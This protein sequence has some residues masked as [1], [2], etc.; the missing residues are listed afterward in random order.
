MSDPVDHGQDGGWGWEALGSEDDT[1]DGEAEHDPEIEESR[2]GDKVSS[3]P[4]TL[5]EKSLV[6]K[7]AISSLQGITSS[8]SFQE[9]EKAIGATLALNLSH[10][11][12]TELATDGK[13]S[14]SNGILVQR[15]SST[16]LTQQKVIQHRMRQQF[17]QNHRS[18][19]FNATFKHQYPSSV[20]AKSELAPF[21]NESESRA[22]ILFHTPALSQDAVREACSKFGVLYYIRPEFHAKGV[23]FISYFDLQAAT[24][25]KVSIT[26]VLGGS[27]DVSVH[28]SIMLHATNSNTEEFRLVVKNL[29]DGGQEGEI[30]SI[31][32]R[33]GQLR[34]IQKTF[35]S[36]ADLQQAAQAKLATAYS[37]EYYNIQDAR[38]AA[39]ELSAT[40]ANIWSPETT[41]KFAP[42]DERKQ[43][44]CQQLLATLSRW[45][46]EMAAAASATMQS[47]TVAPMHVQPHV[48][49]SSFQQVMPPMHMHL[50]S[51]AGLGYSIPPNAFPANFINMDVPNV[52]MMPLNTRMGAPVPLPNTA[53]GGQN[54]FQMSG[55]APQS[56]FYPYPPYPSMEIN[57]SDPN[58]FTSRKEASYQT[59]PDH[60]SAKL[61]GLNE[62]SSSPSTSANGQEAKAKFNVSDNSAPMS[63]SYRTD[64]GASNRANAFFAQP[65]M[66]YNTS[67]QTLQ[68]SFPGQAGTNKRGKGVAGTGGQAKDA[69]FSLNIARI[70]DGSEMRTTI[71]VRNIPNKY[72]QQMLLDEVNVHHQGTYDFFY[73][74]I[75]FKNRCNVGY[76]FIN[77][78]DPKFIVPF[79]EE[80]EGQ[81]WKSFNS[82]KICAI[83]FARIQGRGAMIARFQNSSLLEKDEEYKPLLFFSSGP[84]Q[85]KPE[86]FPSK[87]TS[88]HSS[89]QSGIVTGSNARAPD[90]LVS[91]GGSSERGIE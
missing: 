36:S 46:S 5:S 15:L 44:L 10:G 45:R 71:M 64:G 81:R 59:A 84:D 40:S 1:P 9:L 75:D 28:Y 37:I 19:S 89:E 53:F 52:G 12:I 38:L 85:G 11:D 29:P 79:V 3:L 39:S 49:F 56:P 6:S 73:L 74:P 7:K 91:K 47:P 13:T 50:M 57:M 16:N 69:D 42:L 48:A 86:A 35:A 58:V 66:T 87:R 18:P 14:A 23:T 24:A 70:Q 31:F 27:A 88:S 21:I 72:N 17:H 80:F 62:G 77:F 63:S 8:P 51:P 43:N 83:T 26:D 90:L 41:V 30:Q 67:R 25:A 76:C 22:L 60:E 54:G 78:L 68:S 82:E 34:S 33:Y 61:G 4:Q 55:L 65:A 2:E 32:A 20:P